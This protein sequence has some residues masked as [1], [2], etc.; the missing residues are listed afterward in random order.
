[1]WSWKFLPTPGRSWTTGT[2][3]A[4]SSSAGPIPDSSSSRGLLTAPL[5]K[6]SSR[7]T[8]TSTGLPFCRYC[9]PTA[10]PF[11]TRIFRPS[12]WV[13][14]VRFRRLRAGL[15]YAVAVLSRRA[16]FWVTSYQLTP[17]WVSPLKSAMNSTPSSC[18]AR[19]N[20]LL[21][22]LCWTCSVTFTAPTL[23]W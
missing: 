21:R 4:V 12:A 7:S 16:F 1:M 2:P 13:W 5:L 6:I 10:R 18:A 9:S 15:R 23:L 11:S 19:T 8:R 22:G 20:A 17:S 3:T 14:M